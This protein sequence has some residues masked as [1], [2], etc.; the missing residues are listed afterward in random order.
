MRI[1]SRAEF[2]KLPA[3][4]LFAK[5]K[6]MYFGSLCVKGDSLESDWIDRQLVWFE[7]HGST[8][9][10]FDQGHRW[11]EM[12][13]NGA[14]FPMHTGYGRDGCFDNEDLFLIYERDDLLELRSVIDAALAL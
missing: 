2:M 10:E 3:G 4:T 5:G 1:V 13:E 7:E 8:G 12:V 14:S 9:D 11:D 6:P